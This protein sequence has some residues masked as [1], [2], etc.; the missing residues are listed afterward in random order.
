[1]TLPEVKEFIK[2]TGYVSNNYRGIKDEYSQF[3]GH[4]TKLDRSGKVLARYYPETKDGKVVGYKCR[5]SPKDFR[6]GKLGVTGLS[7]ELSGQVKFKSYKNHRDI[8]VVA[9]E[10]DKAAAFQ[11]LR[12]N[13]KRKGQT[14]YEPVAV[15]SPTAGEGSAYK[16]LQKQYDFLNQFENIIIGMDNDE[17]G[18]EATEKIIEVLPKEKVKVA[19]W[20]VKDPNKMLQDGKEKQFLSDFYNA[21][22][23]I[24]DGVITSTTADD[25]IE[26]ELLKPK[27]P[28]PEFMG[29]LQKTFAGGIPLGYWVNWIAATGAGKTTTVNEAIRKWVYESPYKVG[30]LSLELTAA[31][32]M[33]AMVSRE[34]GYKINLISNPEEA[35]AF[36][37]QP[38]V[39]E[40]RNNLKMNEYGEDR[41]V[42][43][44]DREGTLDNVKRQIE[45]LIKKHG[46]KLIVIDPLNDLFEASSWDEQSAF[47]KWMK[48]IVKTGVIFSC[49]C[50]VRKGGV[51]TDKNG[52][53]IVRELTEDDVSGLSL[54]TKSAGANVFLT[55]DK[56]SEDDI[57]RNTTKVTVGK[58]R[59]TG[60][61][62]DAGE[63]YYDNQTHT[64]H[65]KKVFFP[66]EPLE[67]N[68]VD[69]MEAVN[70]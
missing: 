31:Q 50:H 57:I 1:M 6:Y 19:H 33:I 56:Y 26:E 9:G 21:K 64:M 15:V 29:E 32:Y 16:Q 43:V 39:V 24:S 41:F 63:W 45:T 34:V 61:T 53:R 13:Q 8:L 25:G 36:I 37:K 67:D 40:A 3:F 11:M 38:H 22:P 30:I 46:C 44:D 27:V 12:D 60:L 4:L 47:I 52:K 23:V 48:V 68:T 10:E 2:N 14:E 18:W 35:V 62:G 65:D 66:E 20:S 54:I 17:A 28:L 70:F 5:N 69:I 51:S 49:V 59:W 42:L 58:C 55:R 7:C